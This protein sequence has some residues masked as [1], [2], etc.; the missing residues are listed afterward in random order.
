M[1]FHDLDGF[2]MEVSPVVFFELTS[3]DASFLTI[4]TEQHD[5]SHL[6]PRV[7]SIQAA[8]GGIKTQGS[9]TIM[10]TSFAVKFCSSEIIDVDIIR[11]FHIDCQL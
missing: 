4:I 11:I 7:L 9:D 8:A 2:S 6:G 1:T 5:K 10:M 3:L